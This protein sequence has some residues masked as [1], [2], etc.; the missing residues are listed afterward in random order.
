MEERLREGMATWSGE[1]EDGTTPGHI[2]DGE[3]IPI[4]A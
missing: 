3:E 4:G 2:D 1:L